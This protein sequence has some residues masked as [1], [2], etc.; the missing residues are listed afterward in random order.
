MITTEPN[1]IADSSP[2]KRAAALRLLLA[3]RLA[4]DL[5]SFA[6]KG[7]AILNP[8]RRLIWSWHYDYLCEM[9]TLVK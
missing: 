9:L 3:D 5:A 4:G 1:H 6:K 8:T 7:W 2:L